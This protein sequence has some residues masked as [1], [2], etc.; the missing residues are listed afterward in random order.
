MFTTRG[1][2][3]GVAASAVFVT[4]AIMSASGCS[5]GSGCRSLTVG[6]T[7]P[8]LTAVTAAFD[9]PATV[10]ASGRPLG[11]VHVEFWAWGSPPGQTSQVGAPLGTV[12][13][14]PDGTA[15]LH[16]PALAGSGEVSRLGQLGGTD[17]VRVSGDVAAVT[18]AGKPYC[19]AKGQAPV[20]NCGSGGCLVK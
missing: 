3:A 10:T 5:S 19:A 16:V 18:L 4:A 13:T 9:I 17:L 1:S 15:T 8:Q 20:A 14:G 11:G 12:V 2:A 7:T 6:L